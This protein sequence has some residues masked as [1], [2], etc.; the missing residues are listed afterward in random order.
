MSRK[1]LQAREIISSDELKFPSLFMDSDKLNGEL[2]DYL[3]EMEEEYQ[4]AL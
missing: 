1:R 2:Q 3:Q 4:E